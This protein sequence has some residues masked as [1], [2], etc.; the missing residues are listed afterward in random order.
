LEE[1]RL[2]LHQ[3]PDEATRQTVGRLLNLVEQLHAQVQALTAENQQLRDEIHRLKG[4][5]GRPLF[6]TAR[7]PQPPAPKSGNVS[8]EAERHQPKPHQKGAKRDRIKV[9]RQEFLRVDPALL[10]PDAQCK[11][12]DSVVVQDLVVRT[13]NVLF[14][15]E[16]YYSPAQQRSYRAELPPGYRG[17][18]RPGIRALAVSLAYSGHM[19]EGQIH[20]LFTDVGILIARGT[21]CAFLSEGHEPFH[22]EAA[23]V[24]E[25]GLASSPWQH[26]DD[27]ATRV[28]GQNQVCYV[29]CNPLYTHYQTRANKE[30]LT[31]LSVLQG[32]V[33]PRYRLDARAL[34]YLETA[35]VARK[36]RRPL[37]ALAAA[38]APDAEWTE[39]PFRELLARELPGLGPQQRQRVL[40]AAALAAYH[41][42]T[43]L[44]V[45]QTLVCDDA[46]QFRQLTAEVALCWVHDGR[47]YAKLLPLLPAH[48]EA[49]A[50]FRERYWEFYRQLRAYQE[51]P[52]AAEATR[53][54]AAFDQLFETQTGWEILDA[55]IA[56][57]RAKKPELLAVL[58][59]PELPLHNNPAELG[60]RRRV[61]K[62]DVS[63]GPRT[64]AG[65]QAWDT[66][67]TLAATAA[68]LGVS[69]YQFVQDRMSG[70][71]RLPALATQIGEQ[72][73]RLN[74]GHSWT[75]SPT[76]A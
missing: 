49:L 16:V 68:K 13:D 28:N 18:Y 48:R 42:Q 21:V 45:V 75:S 39:A 53:L 6:P 41:A 29:L 43:R 30:R 1:L 32:G 58:R 52:T 25:A 17:E 4:E 10:P 22:A 35:G 11:G 46:P 24:L 72:A 37:A 55:R 74:W 33:P 19:S 36:V 40:E 26:L 34:A 56:L 14:H 8:S 50:Q 7:P 71:N 60:A 27:T 38:R 3:I 9:D 2:D 61:R 12:Y 62:R 5:R 64:P 23:A 65:T 44:P 76:S 67:Q 15:K 66:F 70:A 63:F 57:T 69:F 51:A 59:H 73:Q 31:V 54:V 47:H 20:T